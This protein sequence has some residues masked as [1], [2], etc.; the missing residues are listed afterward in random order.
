MEIKL[1]ID[2]KLISEVI[3]KQIQAG[4]KQKVDSYMNSHVVNDMITNICKTELNRQANVTIMSDRVRELMDKKTNEILPDA[5]NEKFV[6]AYMAVVIS[7][8]RK[9][10]AAATTKFH[11]E[12]NKS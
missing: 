12:L 2:D 5:L 3:V 6:G 11:A 4:V 7:D 9:H 8:A 1:E 10:A